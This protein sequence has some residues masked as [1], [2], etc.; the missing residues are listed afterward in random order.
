MKIYLDGVVESK[1][2]LMNVPYKDKD[3]DCKKGNQLI[4]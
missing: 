3:C 4:P 2:A 1:T